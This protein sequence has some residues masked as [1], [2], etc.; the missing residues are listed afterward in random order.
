MARVSEEVNMDKHD[1]EK[2]REALRSGDV[3]EADAAMSRLLDIASPEMLD[4]N[5][6][7]ASLQA[8][9]R[10][11]EP[12]QAQM[13][14][15]FILLASR[16]PQVS[17]PVLLDCL[18]RS[19]LSS[20]GRLSVAVIHEVLENV[21]GGRAQLDRRTTVAALLGAVEAA[22][23]TRTDLAPEAVTALHDWAA[24]EPLPEAGP[25]LAKWLLRAAD[26]QSPNEYLLRLARE[27][28]EA[29]SQV[30]LLSKV[31]ERAQ[32]LSPDHA[33]RL[34]IKP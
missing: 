10:L 23:H 25:A 2:L 7:V 24:R 30:S 17:V 6:L 27:T 34:A 21:P 19:P 15:P 4:P 9:E 22:A 18:N 1:E 11:G 29:N 5:D 16:F 3:D 33:L 28:L 14:E 8:M 31:R 12:G 13:F 20:S 26:E 32:S